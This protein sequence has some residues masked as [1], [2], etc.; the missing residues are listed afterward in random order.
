MILE[1]CPNCAVRN[2]SATGVAE[3]GGREQ[4][5]WRVY[6]CENQDCLKLV[7]IHHK[8]DGQSFQYPAG[9]FDLP[10]DPNIPA[11]VPDEYR[12]AGTC[13]AVGCYL[14]SM[15]MSRRVLQRCLK[16]QGFD[17]KTLAQQIDAAKADGTIPKRYHALAD[18]IRQYGNIGAHPDDDQAHLVTADNAKHLLDFVDLLIHE[19]Y[20]LPAKVSAMTKGRIK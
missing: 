16:Q 17:Q 4:G 13:K 8:P 18:E 11:H 7:F 9:K 5:I 1:Q 14:A 6:R 19:F 12:Q 3:A 10:N 20:E 15:T 2:T